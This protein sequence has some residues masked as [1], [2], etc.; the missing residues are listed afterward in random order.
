[1]LQFSVCFRWPWAAPLRQIDSTCPLC[2]LAVALAQVLELASR[3]PGLLHLAYFATQHGDG[4][5]VAPSNSDADSL[6]VPAGRVV[7][8]RIDRESLRCALEFASAAPWPARGAEQVRN[9]CAATTPSSGLG[10]TPVTQGRAA[11]RGGVDEQ[12]VLGAPR[13]PPAVYLC[14]PP[15]FLRDLEKVLV[16]ELGV[17]QEHV[18]FER[19]W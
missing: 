5:G 13:T 16:T 2:V 17:R 11:D 8:G 15:Q 1:M 10:T 4:H 3:F 9:N 7:P 18:H 19:W 14:G 6:P 12:G